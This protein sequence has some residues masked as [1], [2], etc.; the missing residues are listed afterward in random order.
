MI[1]YRN[2]ECYYSTRMCIIDKKDLEGMDEADRVA[3]VPRNHRDKPFEEQKIKS[4][5]VDTIG[6][7]YDPPEKL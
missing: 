5:T 6:V 1:F 2:P 7:D 3:S 4:I